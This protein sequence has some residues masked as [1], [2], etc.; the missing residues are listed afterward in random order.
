MAKPPVLR[1]LR[2][3]RVLLR[4]LTEA[5]VTVSYVRWMNDAEI[6]RYLESRYTTHTAEDILEYVRGVR[7]DPNSLMWA[8]CAAETGEHVGNIKLGPV[9]WIHRRGDI[10]LMIGERSVWGQGY[11][12]EAISLLSEYAFSDLRLH[13]LIAGMYEENLGS[14]KAFEKAGFGLEGMRRSHF[15]TGDGYTDAFEMTRFR[16]VDR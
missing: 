9:D 16:E 2:G 11:A 5:D 3:D 13:K 4:E 7:A 1:E 6:V 8:I 10:G 14:R 12:M 15:W